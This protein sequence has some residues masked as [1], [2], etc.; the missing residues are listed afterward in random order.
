MDMVKRVT[1]EIAAQLK[2]GDAVV[3]RSTVKIGTTRDVVQPIL[4]ATG[5]DFD[6]GFCPERTLEGRALYELTHLP[7]II[8]A[9]SERGRSGWPRSSTR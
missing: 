2:D 8:G 1:A 5:R 3:L 7:Q 9:N 4:A 6:I